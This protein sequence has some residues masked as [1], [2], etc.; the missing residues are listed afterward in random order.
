MDENLREKPA[1]GRAE[2]DECGKH[3]IKKNFIFLKTERTR[4]IK[5]KVTFRHGT[6]RR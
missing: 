1:E 2:E 4:V 5:T 6:S 3:K